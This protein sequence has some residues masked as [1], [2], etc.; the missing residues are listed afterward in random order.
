MSAHESMMSLPRDGLTGALLLNM[1]ACVSVCYW[2]PMFELFTVKR[3]I[4]T[5]NGC[6]KKRE[7]P[8]QNA[9]HCTVH[10]AF[11]LN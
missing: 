9:Q 7:K 8:A 1:C 11:C 5:L 10:D 2:V 6:D 3:H 4:F